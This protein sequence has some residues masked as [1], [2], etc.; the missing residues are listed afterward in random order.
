MGALESSHPIITARYNPTRTMKDF[1]QMEESLS[2][3]MIL[4]L[5]AQVLPKQGTNHRV[6]WIIPLGIQH[7]HFPHPAI[8]VVLCV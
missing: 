7:H 6:L 4:E 1:Y 5:L 8:Y 3:P 2:V